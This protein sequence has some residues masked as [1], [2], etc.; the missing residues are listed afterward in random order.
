[1]TSALSKTAPSSSCSVAMLAGSAR[2][3]IIADATTHWPRGCEIGTAALGTFSGHIGPAICLARIRTKCP[4]RDV[5]PQ[6][7]PSHCLRKR[8]AREQS[9]VQ[10]SQQPE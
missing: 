4:A 1:M 7:D 5:A 3:I 10:K 6:P 9:W 8:L 2:C